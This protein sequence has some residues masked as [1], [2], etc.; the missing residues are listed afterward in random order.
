MCSIFKPGYFFRADDCQD[1]V[2]NCSQICVR[3]SVRLRIIDDG[4]RALPYENIVI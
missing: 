1:S 3:F 4:W 2:K